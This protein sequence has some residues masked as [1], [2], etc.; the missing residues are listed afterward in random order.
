M[1]P[2]E[3][4]TME[5]NESRRATRNARSDRP[6]RGAAALRLALPL[7]ALLAGA[8]CLFEAAPAKAQARTIWSSTLNGQ[9]FA[10]TQ[11][12]FGTISG[13]GC[14]ESLNNVSDKLCRDALTEDRF[15]YEGL[16][17]RVT[18]LEHLTWVFN[19]QTR[20][21]SYFG[22]DR[23]IPDVIQQHGTLVIGNMRWPMVDGAPTSQGNFP[24]NSVVTFNGTLNL[25]ASGQISVSLEI[26]EP[27]VQFSPSVVHLDEGS[28][29]TY[30][31]RL[32]SAPT[33]NVD[34]V[35]NTN[36]EI[37]AQM[38]LNPLSLNFTST[39]WD[40]PQPIT[41]TG[42]SDGDSTHYSGAI[43]H[44]ITSTDTNYGALTQAER[45]LNVVVLDPAA[46]AIPTVTLAAAP[47]PVDEGDSLT[48]TATL[49]A[50]ATTNIDIPITITRGTAE[51]A[52]LGTLTSIR[53][54]A[55]ASSGTGTLTTAQDDT[56]YEDET[57]TISIGSTL[58]PTTLRAVAPSSVD[59][60]IR[61]ND[62][63]GIPTVTLSAT[64]NPVPEG[65]DVS[66]TVE[67]S[68]ALSEAVIIPINLAA[69][70]AN[71]VDYDGTTLTSMT[72]PAGSTSA[73]ESITTEEDTDRKDNE[74][75]T[76]S[77]GTPL[78]STVRAGSPRSVVVT[79]SEDDP[80]ALTLEA[81]P[82]ARVSPGGTVAV[83]ASLNVAPQSAATVTVTVDS[84]STAES[85]DYTITPTPT[86]GENSLNIPTT[87]YLSNNVITIDVEPNASAGTIVLDA[88]IE[89]IQIDG[90]P[91]ST[92]LV[93]TI[94]GDLEQLHEA[95]LPEV[96]RAVA[97]RVGNAI[98]ARVGQVLNGERQ[99]NASASL[100]GERTLAGALV[101][102]APDVMNGRRPM[103]D[104][105]HNADFVLPLN[106]NG[107]GFSSSASLWGSGQYTSLSGE[108]AGQEFDGSLQGVQ[109]GV[110]TKLREDLLAGLALSWS[111][112]AFDYTSEGG[113]RGDYEI[114]LLSLHPYLG[115]RNEQL[116]WWASAGYGSGEVEISPDNG[117]ASSNDVTLWT[118]GAGGNRPMWV[119][120]AVAN[121]HL[122]GE[123]MQT[124]MD[125]EE[126]AEV[127]SLSVNA[128][129]I[130]VALEAS[131]KQTL[132]NHRSLSPSLSLGARHDGGDGNTGTGMEMRGDVHYD[133]PL[134]R[135][136]ASFSMHTLL[137]RSD[138]EEWGIQGMLR[139]SAGADGQGLSFVMRPGYGNRANGGAGSD[140]IWSNGLRE[141]AAAVRDA[142]EASGNLEMRLG[143]GLSAPGGQD[144]LLTPWSGM[145]LQ[146][147]GKR[148]RMGLDW[149]TA[150]PFS[151][152]LH[153]ERRER[154]NADADHLLLLKGE[155]RF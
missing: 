116:E 66:I 54:A 3:S 106:G 26:S 112:G 50:A 104:L 45:T 149:A 127:D 75:F 98:S 57:F 47:N 77:L 85:G 73:T 153:G 140:S 76:V 79:I 99:G 86:A 139:L 67:M 4:L 38:S 12:V 111:Q 109:L 22:F 62:T 33:A 1:Y 35:L 133:N 154:D 92:K 148:Y 41:V 152:R 145:T 43:L 123:V 132:T 59:V 18:F 52:D 70:T 147:D 83:T 87:T 11:D 155:M 90:E 39:N 36:A 23:T 49:S 63:R 65:D 118:V 31:V 137:G 135:V 68:A 130:R 51:A 114:D 122:K 119:D 82:S 40:T 64:P 102:H 131:R 15:S 143:Y 107:G 34:V 103:R 8:L 56:D 7:C 29:T 134:T 138:Y 25:P 97:G 53:I 120:E 20:N 125:I 129:L 69:G 136:S 121:L 84:D 5:T 142:R 27:G 32:L 44:S 88:V 141:N 89:S 115:G 30:T 150:G 105:L 110:D 17:Y 96:A 151:V 93:I 21:A 81:K 48:V 101:T 2:R 6:A 42:E 91:L 113:K 108:N 16:E 55:G 61:D 74:T 60:V 37:D 78:P 146:D 124:Q 95:V 117:V 71:S 24:D 94:A 14:R 9:T 144:G 126:S 58:S 72:I 46:D 28:T 10:Y 128:T 13:T 100:G 80:V 19:G